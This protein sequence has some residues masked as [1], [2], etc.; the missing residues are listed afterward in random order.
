MKKASAKLFVKLSI[1]LILLLMPLATVNFN[2]SITELQKSPVAES[3]TE[4]IPSANDEM[5]DSIRM[6][7]QTATT[8]LDINQVSNISTDVDASNKLSSNTLELQAE[9]KTKYFMSFEVEV[10]NITGKQIMLLRAILME[11]ETQEILKVENF[12]AYET[13]EHAIAVETMNLGFHTD[14]GCSSCG[15]A[16]ESFGVRNITVEE[17]YFIMTT[18]YNVTVLDVRTEEEYTEGHIPGAILIPHDELLVRH[19]DLPSDK[20]AP[21]IVYCGSGVRSTFAANLLVDMGYTRVYNMYQGFNTWK[22]ADYPYVI[23]NASTGITNSSDSSTLSS[24]KTC[25]DFYRSTGP[26]G[27]NGECPVGSH[28]EHTCV[29]WNTEGICSVITLWCGFLLGCC[30][31]LDIICCLLLMVCA[32]SYVSLCCEQWLDCCILEI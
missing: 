31:G 8:D 12:I 29:S 2:F 11:V 21:I 20:N 26:C 27:P 1:T 7:L 3:V 19:N 23:E 14:C 32:G 4:I 15:L 30:A 17:A 22:N 9:K 10:L 5:I 25:Y 6:P 28:C 16:S 18:W 13:E 24:S